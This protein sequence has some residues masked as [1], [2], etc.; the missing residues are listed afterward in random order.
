MATRPFWIVWNP[1][2]KTP[3][4]KMLGAKSAAE[5]AAKSLASRVGNGEIFYVLR[6]QCSYQQQ[7][8]MCRF[9]ETG[10]LMTEEEERTAAAI[11]ADT[12]GRIHRAIN[13]RQT[14]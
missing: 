5:R 10:N 6:A 11:G 12:W 4:L 9:P 2:G 13:S 8:E 1:D 7:V 14:P 3:P